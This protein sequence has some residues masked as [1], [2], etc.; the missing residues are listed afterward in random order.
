MLSCGM[1]VDTG[2]PVEGG[3]G[4]PFAQVLTKKT[5]N[6]LTYHEAHLTRENHT[7]ICRDCCTRA[8][9]MTPLVPSTAD[10]KP[11]VCF[12]TGGDIQ[13]NLILIIVY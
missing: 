2:E 9:G 10:R 7:S 1:D 13:P 3:A 6:F 5:I 4:W 8:A 12:S 11:L